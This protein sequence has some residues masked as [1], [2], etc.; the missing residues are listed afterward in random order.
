MAEDWDKVMAIARQM[1]EE[2]HKGYSKTA[3]D[4][5]KNPRYIEEL[6]DFNAFDIFSLIAIVLLSLAHTL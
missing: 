2:A 5:G 4:H 1:E 6:E 3:L